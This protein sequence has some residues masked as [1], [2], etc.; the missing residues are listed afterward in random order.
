MNVQ[1]ALDELERIY[2][3]KRKARFIRFFSGL[4]HDFVY[5]IRNIFTWM[6]IIWKDRQWDQAYLYAILGKK[7][8]RMED[9]FL[10][11]NTTTANAKKHGKDIKVARIL[12]NRLE[13]EDYSNPNKWAD[14]RYSNRQEKQDREYLFDLMKKHVPEW[15]D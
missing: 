13:R 5:G 3:R 14:W 7:L 4:F 10:S 15:W 9:F 11:G 6:P 12:C 1:E 8:K 2:K